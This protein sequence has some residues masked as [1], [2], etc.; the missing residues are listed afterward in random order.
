MCRIGLDIGSTTAKLAVFD[1]NQKLVYS[2]YRRHNTL[3]LE[4][5]AEL[6]SD[7]KRHLGEDVHVS[8]AVTGSAGIGL[9]EKIGT[10]FVQEVVAATEVIKQQYP[11]V[12][13]LMD[14]GGE[15]SKLIFFE[16]GKNPDIRMNGNC[17]GGT[18]AFIDQMASL[19]N[20]PMQEV[21]EVAASAT[22]IYPI[23]SRCGV[24][25]KTDVQNLSNRKVPVSDIMASVFHAVA[26]QAMNTLVRGFTIKPK[27]MFI[28]GPFSFIPQLQIVFQ[29]V[30][31]LNDADVVTPEHPELMPAMGAALEAA[32]QIKTETLS[33][34]INR[35]HQITNT[36][37]TVV[38][39]LSPLFEDKNAFAKWQEQRVDKEV[40]LVDLQDYRGKHAFLG[41]DSGSTTTKIVLIGEKQELLFRYYANNNGNAIQTVKTGLDA[42]KNAISEA[43]SDVKITQTAVTGYGEDLMKA[44]FGLDLGLVETI[45][46]YKA[47]HFLY[48]DL[49][50]IMDIGGQDMKAI[51]IKNKMVNKIE[52]NESCSS[53]CGSFVENFANSLNYSAADFAQLACSAEYP[54]DLGTR[55][56]VFMNSKVKQALRENATTADISAGLAY[57]VIKNALYKVL[58]LRDVSE[59]GNCIV[60]HGGTF[61]NPAIHRALELLSGK[62]VHSSNIPE[63]MGAYGAALSAQAKYELNEIQ[64]TFI[65]LENQEQA[66][67]SKTQLLN[68]KGCENNCVV[69]KFTFP[70][71]TVFYSGNK[72]EKVFSNKG[73]K[74]EPGT[75]L[76]EYK[77]KLLFDRNTEPQIKLQKTIRI[78]I[79]RALGIYEHFPFW[80]TLFTNCGMRVILS[81][82]S[83]M[84]LY[85]KGSGT[86]MS[87]SI[88]FPAKL[89]HGHV[90]ELAENMVDRI[91]YPI[92]VFERKEYKGAQ[93]TYNCPIVSGYGDVIRSSINPEEKYKTPIDTPSMHFG[94]EKLLRRACYDYVKPFG[95]NRY[96][97]M[98]AFKAAA[99]EQE[100]YRT[101]LQEAVKITID[102]ADRENRQLVI[103]AG[104]P[105]HADSLIN[106]KTPEMLAEMGVDVI[107]EHLLPE[108]EEYHAQ[109]ISQWAYP[110]RIY[111]AAAWVASK[112][113]HVQMVQFNSFGCGPDA[114][115][116]DEC[117]EVLNTVGKNHTLIKIDE[118]TSTGSVRLRLRSMI[119][120]LELSQQE[121]E[122]TK[123][124]NRKTTPPFTEK[125]K[126]RLILAPHFGDFYSPFIP[127]MF[128]LSGYRCEN[129]P[130][131][132]KQSVREGLQYANNEICYPATIVVGDVIKALKSG[133]YKREE[134]AVGITQTGGQCRASNYISLIKKA[135]IAAGYDDIP[136]VSV[137]TDGLEKDNQPGLVMQWRK[138]A[139][140]LFATILYADSLSKLYYATIVR[141]KNKG[142]ADRARDTFLE[143]GAITMQQNKP[144]LMFKLLEEAVETFNKIPIYNKELPKIGIV[145]EIFVKYNSFAHQNIVDWMIEQEIEV[146]VPPL[147]DFFMQ[148]F[149]NMDVNRDSFLRR[150]GLAGF[151][152]QF[153]EKAA[154]KYIRKTDVILQKF[155][156]EM[157]FHGIRDMAEK[158]AQVVNLAQQFGEGWLIPAEIATFAEE[159]VHNVVSVQPF[160]CIANH[161]ISKGI[162]KRIKDLYPDMN[163]LF[164]DFDDGTGEVNVL[165]RLHFM[166]KNAKN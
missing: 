135:M 122:I 28:G 97:F 39:R 163:L 132:D 162:E 80:N 41:I 13:V 61:K 40:P 20:I 157:H 32:G 153:F 25:A 48:P 98:R 146:V 100:K 93:N 27:V 160:G 67:S 159:N 125:D 68:C 21:S 161:V 88:C 5:V 87:D 139:R 38:D 44:A 54:C 89:M 154:N 34:I 109:V 104:R 136:V 131:P 83:T 66:V 62:K 165:N 52:L 77:N 51:F 82:P 124:R 130:K 17:A 9:S 106:H 50:F 57:A 12:H 91:F 42:L 23:A 10:P 126:D 59:L 35:I 151:L 95:V 81:G 102:R 156:I 74:K 37:T 53:G 30:M 150:T 112:G 64:T 16:N 70:N 2:A 76:F 56:T 141:E 71:Q 55:C 8:F 143:K 115:V 105:Y 31:R 152:M 78:G 129:L 72:C 79:P 138:M 19:L 107:P 73:E 133:K 33:S 92:T 1:E 58:K 142:D 116:I 164:L 140:I 119:E 11:D 22:Q 121:R 101:D 49:S 60:V 46:H 117:A 63:L 118:I 29:Q 15:E 158:A 85:L 103:L 137:N 4:V 45:A 114:V 94:D 86:V 24:F 90:I 145:G 99:K 6:L 47:A 155:H 144:E 110:N 108:I 14:I 149:V 36:Q 43:K 3:I 84:P 128:T 26:V 7:V 120:S 134:I 113:A 75:N 96:Q 18:G 65:G 147:L 127:N 69:S 166:V 111:N 123:H 148:M